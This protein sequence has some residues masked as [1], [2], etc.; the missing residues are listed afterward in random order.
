MTFNI[1][2]SSQAHK[3]SLFWVWHIFTNINPENY[4]QKQASRVVLQTRC[5]VRL[6]RY[7]ED[8]IK[9][10]SWLKNTS[11]FFADVCI[12]YSIVK[13]FVIDPWKCCFL[14]SPVDLQVQGS[15]Q[16]QEFH[17]VKA[18]IF[19]FITTAEFSGFLFLWVW[20]ST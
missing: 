3:T 12:Y 8:I 6:V 16:Q 9:H 18:H 13:Y 15:A 17:P 20:S 7:N 2:P 19:L 1:S 14:Q 5:L 11:A 10:L 4:W